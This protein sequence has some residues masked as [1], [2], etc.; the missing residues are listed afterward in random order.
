VST[1]SDYTLIFFVSPLHVLFT[2][3]GIKMHIQI[4]MI[5]ICDI[6]KF[7]YYKINAWD[8]N[9]KQDPQNLSTFNISIIRVLFQ[10]STGKLP[11]QETL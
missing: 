11:M 3:F 10:W 2:F 7:K 4:T 1:I 6:D 5:Y 9:T 8:Q